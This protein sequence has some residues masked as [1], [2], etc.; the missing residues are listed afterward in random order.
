MRL[1]EYTDRVEDA[2]NAQSIVDSSLT[3]F[4]LPMQQLNALA[5]GVLKKYAEFLD[6]PSKFQSLDLISI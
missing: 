1:E 6:D 4:N 2:L 3:R 5:V